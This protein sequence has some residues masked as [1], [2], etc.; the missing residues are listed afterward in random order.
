METCRKCRAPSPVTAAISIGAHRHREDEKT[1]ALVEFGDRNS[2]RFRLR[3]L[4]QLIKARFLLHNLAENKRKQ[5]FVVACL[6]EIF[7]ET[8]FHRTLAP[9]PALV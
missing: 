5:F 4:L 8:L 3:V 2:D 7:A 6:S 9:E 1:Y